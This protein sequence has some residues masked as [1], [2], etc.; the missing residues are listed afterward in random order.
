MS[1]LWWCNNVSINTALCPTNWLHQCRNTPLW[2]LGTT[3]R[4]KREHTST[5]SDLHCHRISR[6]MVVASRGSKL[7]IRVEFKMAVASCVVFTQC[8]ATCPRLRQEKAS[9]NVY[10]RHNFH[11]DKLHHCARF[12]AHRRQTTM[13]SS[14]NIEKKRVCKVCA[15]CACTVSDD[16]LFP[17]TN[18]LKGGLV[19]TNIY[20][21]SQCTC[22]RCQCTCSRQ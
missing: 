9:I 8:P 13:A 19:K 7:P 14:L 22:S 16:I 11:E 15:Q 12:V 18:E 21:W 6:N 4:K 1:G 2:N 3:N 20:K 10:I 5:C 17:T